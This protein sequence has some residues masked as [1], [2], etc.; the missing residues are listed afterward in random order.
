MAGSVAVQCCNTYPACGFSLDA[1]VVE[2]NL[3]LWFQHIKD[4]HGSQH[5][6]APDASLS[7]ALTYS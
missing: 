4:R 6:G 3:P 2:T 5:P 7:S 1:A